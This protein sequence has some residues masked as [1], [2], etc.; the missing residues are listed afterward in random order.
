MVFLFHLLGKLKLERD[1]SRYNYLGL[2]SARVNGVDDAANFRTVRV[3]NIRDWVGSGSG[4]ALLMEVKE[5]QGW[6]M[7]LKL[8]Y[9]DAFA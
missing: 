7:A 8:I 5:K 1:F 2:D 6:E 4:W 3:R 9:H